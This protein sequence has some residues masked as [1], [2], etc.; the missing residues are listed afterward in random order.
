VYYLP[1]YFQAIKGT[2]AEQSGIRCVAYLISN[3]VASLI[4]GGIVTFVGYY[5]PF[6]WFGAAGKF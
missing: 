4:F 6:I 3:T 5:T 1:F 2:T